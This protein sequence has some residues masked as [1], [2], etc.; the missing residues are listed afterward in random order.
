MTIDVGDKLPEAT[1]KV[2]TDD[3]PAE[4]ST[5]QIF[6]G[7]KMVL[8]G[9][10]GAFT[11]TCHKDHLRGYLDNVDAIKAK[12][13]DAIAVVSVNDIWV[14]SA[15]AE[16]TKAK[17]RILFLADGAAQFAKAIGLDIDLSATGMG[18]RSRRYS[19]IVD[20]GTVTQLNI[21]QAR[22]K[23]VDSGAATILT[24]L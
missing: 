23:A 14:M 20:D 5:S 21:E 10:P 8:F 24:Q 15:W 1:F 19:M 17:G 16:A 9:L 18:I 4:M 7:K 22:G 2:M 12:G 6:T 3:G 11:P 13:I